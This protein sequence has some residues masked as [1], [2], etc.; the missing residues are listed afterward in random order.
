MWTT[1][2]YIREDRTLHNDSYENLK[3]TRLHGVTSQEWFLLLLSSASHFKHNLDMAPVANAELCVV[4]LQ[5]VWINTREM[6]AGI[7]QGVG[8]HSALCADVRSIRRIRLSLD[9]S[10]SSDELILP[11]G[12]S[13]VCYCQVTVYRRDFFFSWNTTFWQVRAR[14]S[15]RLVRTRCISDSVT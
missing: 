8:G 10:E 12:S 1:R 6:S 5:V 3:W 7:R 9:I 13:G 14:E 15:K 4:F 2:R 11:P